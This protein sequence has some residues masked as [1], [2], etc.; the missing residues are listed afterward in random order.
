MKKKLLYKLI[1]DYNLWI[2]RNRFLHTIKNYTLSQK[3][4]HIVTSCG[5]NFTVKNS[6]SASSARA[7]RLHKFEKPCK[8]CRVSQDIINNFEY[9]KEKDKTKHVR[10]TEIKEINYQQVDSFIPDIS[11]TKKKS[12]N[13]VEKIVKPVIL[14]NNKSKFDNNNNRF[15]KNEK[16]KKSINSH[17]KDG[18]FTQGQKDRI[19]SLLGPEEMI[20]FNKEKRSF[21]ELEVELISKRKYDLITMYEDDRENLLGKLERDITK[22]FVERGFVE[23]KSPILIPIEYIKKMGIDDDTHL[24]QQIFRV[25]E[26]MCLRPM[27]APGLYRYLNKFDN[28]LPDPIRIF[29]IGPCYRKES[30]GKN[31]LEEFTMFNFCQMG[32]NCDEKNLLFLIDDFLSYLN[33][34]YEIESDNSIVYEKTI[35]IIYKNLELSSAVVGPIKQDIDWGI[36]KPWI[37]AGFGLERLLKVIHNFKTIKRSS[38][39]ENYYNGISINL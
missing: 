30:D 32:S 20:S 4:I 15:P 29:E 33:I 35:D 23:I 13:T 26:N 3:Y 11:I 21:Q 22:F 6:R 39:S 16:K 9:K 7:L 2:S 19:V 37:G 38:R 10:I 36:N 28:I 34:N 1:E 8:K 5:E 17:T 25:D 27:L 14:N 24:S 18:D 12:A 31:H